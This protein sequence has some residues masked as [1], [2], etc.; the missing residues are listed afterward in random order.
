MRILLIASL[1]KS[2]V[3]F[4]GDFMK[5]LI[6]NNYEVYAAAPKIDMEDKQDLVALGITPIEF[7]L[8]STGLNPIKDLI[9]IYELKRIISKY[10]ISI[11]FPYTIKPVIYGSIAARIA[12]VP[13][14]SLITGLGFTFSAS[15]MKAK[16]LQYITEIMYRIALRKNRT[17]IFQN[18]DDLELFL[19]RKVIGRNQQ[20]AIVNGSGVNLTKY[21][22]RIKENLSDNIKFVMVARMI[23]E[24]G[25]NIYIES[26]IEIK[27]VYANAEFHVIGAPDTSPSAIKLEWLEELHRKGIIVYHGHQTNVMTFLHDCDV[28]VLPTFYREGVPRS[29]LE[30][31]SIGMPIITTNTPGCRE[32][33][34]N[35]INGFLVE[36]KDQKS[37][38]NAMIEILD[39]PKKVGSMGK[40]SRSLAEE[41]FD[42]HIINHELLEIIKDVLNE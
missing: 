1:A 25:I 28:F 20:V 8:Q 14:I 19:K 29:I 37:L 22:Y 7:S 39:N 5:Y 38:T 12:R 11:V 32:T 15:S 34:K 9:S 30:A 6:S 3:H 24:K 26:A 40:A 42:V 16:F 33:V 17:V 31:L 35:G 2:L 27:K 18:T 36:P 4:R 41:K 21:P 23:T 10:K 13:V